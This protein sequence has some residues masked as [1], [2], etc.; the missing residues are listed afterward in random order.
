MKKTKRFEIVPYRAFRLQEDD[1]VII[2]E[3]HNAWALINSDDLNLIKAHLSETTASS[4]EELPASIKK[5]W[6]A[7]LLTFAGNGHK[8]TIKLKDNYPSSLLLKLTGSCNINCRYCYD[9]DESRFKSNLDFEKIQEAIDYLLLNRDNLGIVFH[10]G[11]P[12]LRFDVIKKT[13]NYIKNKE[14]WKEKHI[15]FQ[16]Q[17]N[18]FL[19]N[20]EIISFLETNNFSVGLSIDGIIEDANVF[21]QN[22]AG[23]STLKNFTEILENHSN[24]IRNR[25]GILTVVSKVNIKHIPSFAIWLQK[26]GIYNLS[27]TFLDQSGKGKTL[28]KYKVTPNEAVWLFQEF[29]DLISNGSITKLTLSP[30]ISRISNLFQFHPKDFC[31][32]GPCAAYDDFIVLDAE[33]NYRTCDCIYHPFFEMGKEIEST[34]SSTVRKNIINRHTWLKTEHPT[35]KNCAL[36]SL[37]GGTCAGKAIAANQNPYSIDDDIECKISQFF[38]PRVLSEFAYSA[39]KPLL[40]YYNFH[41]GKSK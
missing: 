11:E 16:I 35:C 36:F 32:K 21:R 13:V 8:N 1:V 27:F 23:K 5:I 19:F 28:E 39:E 2:A 37:C 9:Y 31:H 41:K 10:G 30:I 3:E 7:G 25:C 15:S 22:R 4:L 38:F 40:N 12:L 14:E 18:G 29:V 6:E 26:Q 33:G 24:F 17:T 20:N 34:E